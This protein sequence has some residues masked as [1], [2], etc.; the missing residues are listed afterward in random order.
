ME[1]MLKFMLLAAVGLAVLVAA[2]W[3]YTPKAYRPKT[4]VKRGTATQMTSG[5]TGYVIITYEREPEET[6]DD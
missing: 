3:D 2:L 4:I 1:W 5:K 6:Y